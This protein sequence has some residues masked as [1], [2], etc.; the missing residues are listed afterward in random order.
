VRC[1]KWQSG[2]ARGADARRDMEVKRRRGARVRKVRGARSPYA[3]ATATLSAHI[4]IFAPVAPVH[5]VLPA[6]TPR[7]RFQPSHATPFFA[8]ATSSRRFVQNTARRSQTRRCAA[9]QRNAPP[10]NNIDV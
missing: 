4:K 1:A 2:D 3:R 8:A 5:H 7:R 10:P 9:R 6:A